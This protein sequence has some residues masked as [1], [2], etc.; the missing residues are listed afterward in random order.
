MLLLLG[1]AY[2]PFERQK[3][4]RPGISY[5]RLV[6]ER[7]VN[8]RG[9]AGP[10]QELGVVQ[11]C[12]PAEVPQPLRPGWEVLEVLAEDEAPKSG[13]GAIT[14]RERDNAAR[15]SSSLSPRAAWQ[16]PGLQQQ[17]PRSWI[18]GTCSAASLTTS[19][20]YQ[21]HCLIFRTIMPRTPRL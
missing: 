20:Y 13:R 18:G 17:P 5:V 9:R 1:F 2:R 3:H 19:A 10:R 7:H 6:R 8:L 4:R 12:P 15:T 21:M 16:P 14:R 11:V